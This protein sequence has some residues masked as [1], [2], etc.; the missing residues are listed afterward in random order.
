MQISNCIDDFRE[1]LVFLFVAIVAEVFL[2][3]V[4]SWS[5][6]VI[7]ACVL[8]DVLLAIS[9]GI[10]WLYLSRTIILDENGCSFISNGGAK[11]FAWEEIYLQHVENSSFLFGDCEIPGEG[12]ILSDKPISKPEYLGA[13][14]YCRFTNPRTSVFIRFESSSNCQKIKRAAAK[15]VY[16]GFTAEKKDILQFVRTK[17]H[18]NRCDN[19][20]N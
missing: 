3:F 11:R 7:I 12:I 8:L 5:D 20:E 10:D 6:I 1:L 15:F 16:Q 2:C 4:L 19:Y 18:I 14:T 9:Y 13:M 17:G